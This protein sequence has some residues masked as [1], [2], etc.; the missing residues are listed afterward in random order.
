[1]LCRLNGVENECFPVNCGLKQSCS[2]S[3][4]ISN[5]FMND[6]VAR[7]SAIGISIDIDGKMLL[8][9]CMQMMWF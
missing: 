7:I 1:M 6:L 4:I 9:F 2:L 5:L 3:P 8:F